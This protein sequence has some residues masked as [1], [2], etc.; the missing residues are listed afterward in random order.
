MM[1]TI[2]EMLSTVPPFDDPKARADMTFRAVDGGGAVFSVGS[3]TWIASLDHAD[4]NNDVARITANAIHRF[5]DHE[6]FDE[7]GGCG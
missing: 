2:E 7:G 5:L 4:Y 6:P 1:R 3:M